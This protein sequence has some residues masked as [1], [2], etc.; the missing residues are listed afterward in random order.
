MRDI[1]SPSGLLPNTFPF[2]V[3][4]PLPFLLCIP[5][6]LP[7]PCPLPLTILCFEQFNSPVLT[8]LRVLL[9]LT[10]I[11]LI[12]IAGTAPTTT[13]HSAIRPVLIIIIIILID[14]LIPIQWSNGQEVAWLVP[15]AAW[16]HNVCTEIIA[17]IPTEMLTGGFN[18]PQV[19]CLGIGAI[20]LI[21]E[22]TGIVQPPIVHLVA[23]CVKRL[24]HM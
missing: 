19:G 1:I 24:P 22:G 4:L 8:T 10:V 23:G 7:F 18:L 5:L 15:P 6:P 14:D 11:I 9:T 12:A 3:S 2:A 21:P 16:W 20:E 17:T 13:W